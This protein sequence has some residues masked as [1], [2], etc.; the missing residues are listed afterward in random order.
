[1]AQPPLYKYLNAEGAKKTLANKCLRFAKPSEYG[2]LEDMT[3]QSLFPDD[4]ETALTILSDGFVDVIVENPHAAPTCSE[5][6]KLKVSELQKILRENPETAQ[7]VK[8]G[9]KNDPSIN[10]FDVKYWRMRSKAF[11]DE[12][13]EFMQGHRVL[14]VT[15]NKNSDRMWKDY[16]QNDQGTVLR[17]EPS[18][19]KDSKFQKFAPVTYRES[20]PSIYDKTLDFAKESLFGDHAARA[21]AIMDRIIY[22]KTNDYK[23]ESEYRLA[24]LLGEGEEDYRTLPYHPEELTELYLGSAMT[25]ADKAEIITKAKGVN[26]KIEIFQ[27]KRDAKNKLSFEKA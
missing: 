12:T 15:T 18:I 2:D 27:G 6:L 5:K 4:I 1:M 8:D 23:F 11:V 25:D 22:A 9:L 16:A 10:A 3:V 20:R 7:A 17:I 24:I 14:C 19:A 26:P 13:N 21:R